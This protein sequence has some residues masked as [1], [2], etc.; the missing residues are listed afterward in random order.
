M[1]DKEKVLELDKLALSEFETLLQSHV[2][3][4]L[5]LDE[6]RFHYIPEP[7]KIINATIYICSREALVMCLEFHSI[8]KIGE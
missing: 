3:Q 2:E 6:V 1:S 7:E 4:H 5:N 8:G